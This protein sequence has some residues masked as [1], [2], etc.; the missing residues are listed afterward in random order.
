MASPEFPEVEVP[1]TELV[2]N[3]LGFAVERPVTDIEE[4][5]VLRDKR[6]EDN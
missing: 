5:A 1:S 6:P 3:P 4:P 2:V